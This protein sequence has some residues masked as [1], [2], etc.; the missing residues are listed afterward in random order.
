VT[1]GCGGGNYCP[2]A[3]VTRGQMAA[4]MHRL[5]NEFELV[6]TDVDPTSGTVFFSNAT[7]PAGKRPIA[8]GGQTSQV[9]LFITD[10]APTSNGWVVRWESDNN[11]T[12]D[13]SSVQV[14]A[15]CAPR[16]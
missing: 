8:G 13:P 15:L 14:F 3:S 1:G 4:F 10:S 11:A 7:C 9:D 6:Q 12:Q 5:S 16:L 2:N